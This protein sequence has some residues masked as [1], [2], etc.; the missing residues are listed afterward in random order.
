MSHAA[1]Q[2][3]ALNAT[4]TGNA[5]VRSA[6]LCDLTPTADIACPHQVDN[7]TGNEAWAHYG[8]VQIE[9]YNSAMEGTLWLLPA[10]VRR[11]SLVGA[12]AR[13]RTRQQ[14]GVLFLVGVVNCVRYYFKGEHLGAL[15]LDLQTL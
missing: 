10:A 1:Q 6:F 13:S 7:A 11:T 14:G 2:L 5:A 3:W 15:V 12:H 4:L 9:G 8:V